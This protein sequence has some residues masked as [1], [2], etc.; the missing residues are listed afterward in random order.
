[1][2]SLRFSR[3]RTLQ[4]LPRWASPHPRTAYVG[5]LIKSF[6]QLQEENIQH[7]IFSTLFNVNEITHG[8]YKNVNHFDSKA[9]IETYIRSLGIPAS[10]F[11]PGFF[12]PNLETE[13]RS[14][15]QSPPTYTMAMPFPPT[16]PI[17][18]FDPG[19][20]AGKFVK[21]M[22]MKRDEVLGK[23]V[24]GATAYS[25]PEDV[26][27][28]FKEAKKGVQAQFVQIDKDTF[29]GALAQAG[30][31][32]YIQVELYENMAFMNDYGYYG[33]RSLDWSHSVSSI[34]KFHEANGADD[35]WCVLVA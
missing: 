1:M 9:A 20:D 3:A 16:T 13:L 5:I 12:M 29:M 19:D 27:K 30:M 17:P 22:V 14:D 28:A 8:V 31:P 32:Q 34:I 33:K 21:A 4:T 26:I 2:I 35:G 15:G 18:W 11:M 6:S 24:L 7:L 10:F 23:N 25:T